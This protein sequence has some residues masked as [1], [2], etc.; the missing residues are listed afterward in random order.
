[1]PPSIG[2]QLRATFD[3]AVRRHEAKVLTDPR[4][5]ARVTDI[6]NRHRTAREDIERLY[7]EEYDQRVE[8]ALA[9][10]N[11]EGANKTYD[12]PVPEGA[13]DAASGET[14]TVQARRR[15]KQEHEQTLLQIDRTEEAE[16]ADLLDDA[17]S[18]NAV[19]DVARDHFYDVADR[20][21]LPD[22]RAPNRS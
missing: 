8:R 5:W 1:M 10:I 21:K 20:R 14:G 15:V 2:E 6:T 22:R 11:D 13:D 9:D 18:R 12:H 4:D 17:R 19:K 7:L 16:I 3:L